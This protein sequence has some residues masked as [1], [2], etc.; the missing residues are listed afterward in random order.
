MTAS[1]SSSIF[2]SVRGSV[3]SPNAAQFWVPNVWGK[4]FDDAMAAYERREMEI[5][6]RQL[7]SESKLERS[8]RR[9]TALGYFER[10]FGSLAI[11]VLVAV[12]YGGAL[13]GVLPGQRGIS[14]EGHLFGFLA[15]VATA[16][17]MKARPRATVYT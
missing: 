15:G 17:V 7:F 1:P 2:P 5:G 4:S 11:A 16:G 14:W 9:I 10:S 8:K 13:W 6:E 12:V 3:S